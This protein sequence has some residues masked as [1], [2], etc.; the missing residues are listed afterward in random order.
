MLQ[1]RVLNI[2]SIESAAAKI[3]RGPEKRK[4]PAGIPIFGKGDS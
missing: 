2:T 1:Y 4:F 3:A